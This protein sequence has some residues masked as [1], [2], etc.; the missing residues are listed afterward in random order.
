MLRSFWSGFE[1]IWMQSMNIEELCG[2]VRTLEEENAEYVAHADAMERMW[3]LVDERLNRTLAESENAD[4]QEKVTLPTP[5]NITI[6]AERMF[7]NLPRVS[8]PSHKGEEDDDDRA[9]KVARWLMAFY[10]RVDKEFALSVFGSLI[11]QSIVLGRHVVEVRW[12]RDELPKAQRNRRL[13]ILV[14]THDPRYVYWEEDWRGTVF[15]ARKYR[16]RW[17]SVYAF[18]GEKYGLMEPPSAIEAS[19]W[20]ELTQ[21]WWMEADGSIWN[22]VYADFPLY[23]ESGHRSG[24]Y[25]N[26]YV[27]PPHKTKYPDIPIIVGYGDSAPVDKEAMRGLSMLHPLKEAWEYENRLASQIGTGLLWF[28]YPTIFI[29]NTMGSIVPKDIKVNPGQTRVLPA[30]LKPNPMLVQTNMQMAQTQLNMVQTAIQQ[31]SF[32]SVMYG[33]AGGLTAGYPMQILSQQARGRTNKIRRNLERTVE[34]MGSLI[35]AQVEAFGG[36]NG[37]RIWAEDPRDNELYTEV[38]TAEDIQGNYDNQVT[39]IPDVPEDNAQKI[40]TWLR[41]VEVGIIS[42]QTFRDKVLDVVGIPVDEDLRVA[43][44]Q[45]LMDEQLRPKAMLR[46]LQNYFP[47]RSWELMIAGTQYEM[48]A[49][50]EEEWKRQEEERKK[51]QRQQ[52][53]QERFQRTGRV[54]AGYQLLPNGTVVREGEMSPTGPQSSGLPPGGPPPSPMGA[55]GPQGPGPLGMGPQGPGPL[56][57]GTPQDTSGALQV[58]G[59]PGLPPELAGQLMPEGMGLPPNLEATNPMLFQQLAGGRIGPAEEMRRIAG[60]Q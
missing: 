1:T 44:E 32:P 20:L 5:Y 49:Q 14:R 51:A 33:D 18:Y 4:S 57:M 12:I 59:L 37:V 24:E 45:A 25:T 15:V 8:V 56:G 35:L 55:M 42:R 39:L 3:A 19:D 9:K 52:K 48:M 22:A 17:G 53:A 41:M 10:Q 34:R 11:W 46:A 16:E 7:S 58:P 60:V 26:Q 27:K 38:L 36:K 30:G 50:M 28:F 29:E 21:C 13:P 23:T 54:P 47:E 43:V 6:L 40:A 31:S 2:R